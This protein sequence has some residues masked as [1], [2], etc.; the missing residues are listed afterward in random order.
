MP[1]NSGLAGLAQ[2]C[3]NAVRIGTVDNRGNRCGYIGIGNHR[4][5]ERHDAVARRNPAKRGN[6]INQRISAKPPPRQHRKCRHA[7]A[8][9]AQLRAQHD[10]QQRSATDNAGCYGIKIRPK[11]LGKIN[12]VH[13]APR[14]KG[15]ANLRN[16]Q[17][18]A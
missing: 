18:L 12:A 11:R 17:R 16:G 14:S 4:P 2:N 6:L 15:R 10:G 3:L 8:Q 5:V 1:L 13:A 7:A 9:I